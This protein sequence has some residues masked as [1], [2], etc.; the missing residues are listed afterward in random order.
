MRSL[1]LLAL[2]TLALEPLFSQHLTNAQ[3]LHLGDTG[4]LTAGALDVSGNLYTAST[5]NLKNLP[6]ESGIAGLFPAGDPVLSKYGPDGTLLWQH[7]FPGNFVRICDAALTPDQ[8][9]IITG[10]YVDTLR[11]APNW[12]IPGDAGN[13]S[14]FVAKL[15][16]EG[17]IIWI[18]TDVSDLPEDCLGWKLAINNDAIYVAGIDDA[19]YASLRRYDFDG[20]LQ[21][22]KI[23]DIRSISDLALDADG[24]LYAAGTASPY[25]LFDSLPV[26]DPPMSTG[27]AN[28]VAQMDGD[29]NAQ[30]IRSTNYITFD[31]HPKVAVFN[32]Q[33]IMLS[34]DFGLGPNQ[35]GCY[36]LKAYS[37]AGDLIWTDSILCA[38]FPPDYQH[39]T[40]KPFCDRLLLQYPSAGG[41][42]IKSYAA[43][44]R[45]SLLL[46][47]S[48]G[49]FDRSFP[50][51]AVQ[52]DRAV[53]GSNFRN[54]ELRFGDEFVLTN[55]QS[56]DYQQFILFL[57]C[58]DESTSISTI[59][60]ASDWHLAP[61][62]AASE[63]YLYQSENSAVQ[64][65]QVALFDAT[66]RLYWQTNTHS[67][68]TVIPV[69]LLPAGSY[70]VR[71]ICDGK[72]TILH[73]VCW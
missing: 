66:G 34:N 23:L 72:T 47:S 3:R 53:F 50:F 33:P 57:E 6:G 21:I 70:F 60:S 12:L 71:V 63:V 68:E 7:E 56:P 55:E 54:A 45:D 14:F 15:D 2:F 49:N 58:A 35:L 62:P 29:L 69:A 46:Q 27:Y 24:H 4:V 26:P 48:V 40:L 67:V 8:S 11:L 39:F 30:W 20:N 1:F 17:H 10:G 73:G 22:E 5:A 59:S 37:S 43:D 61:N 25:A 28:Y 13:S 64:A 9:L 32:G 38:F 41:M 18:R 16:A 52:G 31:E 36:R 51:M 65:I 44:F 42:A 19:I